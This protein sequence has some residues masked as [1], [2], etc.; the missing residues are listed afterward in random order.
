MAKTGGNIDQEAQRVSELTKTNTARVFLN[1]A[2]TTIN[3]KDHGLLTK[4]QAEKVQKPS[5]SGK[6]TSDAQELILPMHLADL[7]QYDQT[8][9]RKWIHMIGHTDFHLLLLTDRMV[10]K[11]QKSVQNPK[12]SEEVR[13]LVEG[14]P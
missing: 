13:K 12:Y 9:F 4:Y 8:A 3:H 5:T 6:K 11:M 1:G 7:Y 10:Q 2:A 14:L